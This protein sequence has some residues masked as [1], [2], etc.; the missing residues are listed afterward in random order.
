MGPL[1]HW[2]LG[3]LAHG[4][5]GHGSLVQWFKIFYGARVLLKL[6][7]GKNTS[8]ASRGG[9]KLAQNGMVFYNKL[10]GRLKIPNDKQSNRM[11]A[12]CKKTILK[13][14][15]CL[16]KKWYLVTFLATVNQ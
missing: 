16:D 7:G 12:G 14:A 13:P 2:F 11:A 10:D 8:N 6:I 4:F 9:K 1:V 15:R 5:A 3:S